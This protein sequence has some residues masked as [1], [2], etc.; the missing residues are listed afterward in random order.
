M[1]VSNEVEML[2]NFEHE[3]WADFYAAASP[4]LKREL[5]ILHG[6]RNDIECFAVRARPKSIL[7]N[8]TMGAGHTAPLTELALSRVIGFFE[9]NEVSGAICMTPQ[10]ATDEAKSLLRHRRF[11]PGYAYRKFARSAYSAIA[12]VE[13]DLA[14]RICQLKEAQQFGDL[15][16]EGFETPT[17]FGTWIS[18]LVG[19]PQWHCFMAFDGE[20]PAATGALYVSNSIGWL[21]FGATDPDHRRR[22]A[23]SALLAARIFEARKL[24]CHTLV[25]ETGEAP[26][27]VPEASY[28]NI[29]RAGF[30]RS[31]LRDNWIRTS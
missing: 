8:H 27:G 30:E 26:D 23:Q 13:T 31:Y 1:V 20:I 15:V 2:E 12:S 16:A 28:R 22:G 4:E 17:R 11:M 7:W 6:V 25:M 21:T 10:A 14:V 3:G 19:R 18:Q 5:G 29:L 9:R 24:G